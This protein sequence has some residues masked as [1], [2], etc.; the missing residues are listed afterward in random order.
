MC[1]T[2]DRLA[3]PTLNISGLDKNSLISKV[4]HILTE[5]GYKLDRILK[6]QAKLEKKSMEEAVK[7][8]NEYILIE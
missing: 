6:I 3:G 1:I 8:V 2:C 7:L 5:R 4:G